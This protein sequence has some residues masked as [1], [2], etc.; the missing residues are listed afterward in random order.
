M[1]AKFRQT[2]PVFSE[3][4][5]PQNYVRFRLSPNPETAIGGSVKQPGER[6]L[7]CMTEL[8]VDEECGTEN[9]LPYEELL[10]D[11]MKGNQTWFA[12]EDYVEESW[13]ILDPILKDPPKPLIYEPGTWGPTEIGN[14]PPPPGGWSSPQ[15]KRL[16]NNQGTRLSA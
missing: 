13:R 1:I 3:E 12:R 15:Q 14:F 9:L 8:T 16:R 10:Q 11:A 2:P 6:L 4:L 7:G 5:T